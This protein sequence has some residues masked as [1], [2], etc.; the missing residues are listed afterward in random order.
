MYICP[1]NTKL[2]LN[3]TKGDYKRGLSPIVL[4]LFEQAVECLRFQAP[5]GGD[6]HGWGSLGDESVVVDVAT[7]GLYESGYHIS[8]LLSGKEFK[9]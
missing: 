2:F 3:S 7:G 1:K 4:F 8:V 5:C 9:L 6:E